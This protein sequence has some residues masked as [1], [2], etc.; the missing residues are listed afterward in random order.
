M[1]AQSGIS[2]S[3]DL[4]EDFVKAVS[5]TSDIRLLVVIIENEVAI[6]KLSLPPHVGRS[7]IEDFELIDDVLED[8]RPAYVLYRLNQSEGG[9]WIFISYV[10]DNAKVR[11]KMLYAS[12]RATISRQL[13]ETHFKESI[14]ATSK[15][16]LTPEGYLAH[17]ASQKAQAPMTARERELADI[18]AAEGISA[19]TMGTEVRSSNVWGANGGNNASLGLKWNPDAQEAL[20]AWC[21]QSG[22]KSVQF[23]IELGTETIVLSENG[24]SDELVFPD[25]QPSYTFYRYS[26]TQESKSLPVFIYACPLKSPVKSR[27]V[28]SSSSSSVSGKASEFGIQLSKK[29]ETS[30]PDEIND[31]YMSSEL[32]SILA[33]VDPNESTSHQPLDK[34]AFAKPARPGRRR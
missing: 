13:G 22:C 3:P 9:S 33:P 21:S 5:K 20:Q 15:R 14:F 28:Y 10:P 4:S 31:D 19:I 16:D 25:S 12:T 23:N 2:V 11:E 27:L 18:K 8:D 24:A 29:F 1:S 32:K 17:L 34:P 7:D 6:T 30:D 26:P